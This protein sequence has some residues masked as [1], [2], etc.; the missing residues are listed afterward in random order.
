MKTK[1]PAVPAISVIVPM[2]NVEEYVPRC[3][4]SLVG[5]TLK[6]IE[7]ILVDDGSPDNS[8]K[9][10]DEYAANDKRIK[11]IHKKN[12]GVAAARNS[13]LDIATGEYIGFCD[14][15]DYVD[16]DF[17]ENLYQIAKNTDADITKGRVQCLN[18]DGTIEQDAAYERLLPGTNQFVC[19]FGLQFINVVFYEK[20]K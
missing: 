13:G 8:G 10:A 19:H 2:W 15:D 14:P 18:L 4:K 17:F 16:S 7:I 1:Y 12:G 3:V 5:Q 11:V 9:L 20:I 6:N